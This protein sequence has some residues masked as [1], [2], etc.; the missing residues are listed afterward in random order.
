MDIKLLLHA[1]VDGKVIEPTLDHAKETA[2]RALARIV[3]LED[4]ID[5]L[6]RRANNAGLGYGFLYRSGHR[7]I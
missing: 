6:E 5:T 7:P 1:W 2:Q 4:Y 3:E